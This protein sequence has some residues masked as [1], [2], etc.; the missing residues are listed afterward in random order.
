M[1]LYYAPATCSL[2]P[3]IVLRALEIPF[4]LVSVDLKS[5][6]LADGTDF[7]SINPNDYVPVL[8]LDDGRRLTEGPAIVQYLAD[9]RPQKGLAPANGTFERYRLQEKLNFITSEL[10]KAFGPLFKPDL[11]PAIGQYSREKLHPRLAQLA[12]EIKDGEFL[13]GKSFTV[14]DAYLFAVL[15]WGKFTQVDIS[16]WPTLQA[17]Y[18]R[19]YALPATQAALKAEGLLR[20]KRAAAG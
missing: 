20:E 2:S 14:A 5:H 10:H 16:Q 18:D 9:L 11:D 15:N 17:Y 6:R 12:R 7:R 13:L 19:V 1:K 4:T 8:E 3:H